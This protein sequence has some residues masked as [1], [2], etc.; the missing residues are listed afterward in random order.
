ML[1]IPS[2]GFVDPRAS[3]DPPR[4]APP[5]P[6]PPPRAAAATASRVSPP[7]TIDAGVSASCALRAP[8]KLWTYVASA[9]SARLSS[10]AASGSIDASSSSDGVAVSPRAARSVDSSARSP[11]SAGPGHF[12]KFSDRNGVACG[13]TLAKT[14]AGPKR[15]HARATNRVAATRTDA[16]GCNVAGAARFTAAT[17]ERFWRIIGGAEEAANATL[18]GGTFSSTEASSGGATRSP[19]HS[20]ALATTTS[21]AS[22]RHRSMHGSKNASHGSRPTKLATDAIR[23]KNVARSDHARSLRHVIKSGNRK[24]FASARPKNDASAGASESSA[25]RVDG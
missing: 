24:S 9:A 11:D 14:S 21:L 1:I 12:A 15:R 3:A 10:L 19:R 16:H 13:N 25:A 17:M 18:P 22:E 7:H 4:S 6:P 8:A 5:P 20:N 2:S 23:R